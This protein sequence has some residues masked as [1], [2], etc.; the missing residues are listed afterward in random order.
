MTTSCPP[1]GRASANPWHE[2]DRL[3]HKMLYWFYGPPHDLARAKAVAHQLKPLL[4]AHAQTPEAILGE[5]AWSLYHEVRGSLL[6]AIKHRKNE[7]R[8]IRRL[9]ELPGSQDRYDVSDVVSRLEL[10]AGLYDEAGDSRRAV[11]LLQEAKDLSEATGLPFEGGD[12]LD[13]ILS[14]AGGKSGGQNLGP[15]RK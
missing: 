15:V 8:L 10:L 14:D 2:I 12:L 7:I 9:L 11:E 3:Y 4:D 1:N 13:E 6:L 5:A